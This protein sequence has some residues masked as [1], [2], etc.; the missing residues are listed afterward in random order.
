VDNYVYNPVYNLSKGVY[1]SVD[2]CIIFRVS[3]GYAY[4]K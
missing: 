1:N 2:M 4:A 3:E